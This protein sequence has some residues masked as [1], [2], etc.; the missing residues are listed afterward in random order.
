MKL[1]PSLCIAGCALITI[2][3]AD[4]AP[5]HRVPCHVNKAK[6]NTPW[7][8]KADTNH[9]GRVSPGEVKDFREAVQERRV[10]DT[11]R[12]ARIDKNDDG[13]IGRYEASRAWRHRQ[14]AEAKR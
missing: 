8:R 12:E 4:A 5:K 13:L 10:V 1:I 11:P 7:E 2:G 6:V 14:A 3:M 9:N